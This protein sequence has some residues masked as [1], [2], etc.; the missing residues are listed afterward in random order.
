ME[1]RTLEVRAAVEGNRLVGHAAVF[2]QDALIRDFYESIDRRAFGRVLR[3]KQDVVLQVDH[4]GLPLART[5]AGTLH[6]GTDSTGLTIDADLAPIGLGNDVRVL[7]DRGDLRSMSFG[8]QVAEDVWTV[9]KDGSQ[10]RT[11]TEVGRLFDVS[12]VTF[13]AYAGTDVALRSEV[14]GT[15]PAPPPRATAR[16]QAARIRWAIRK[17]SQ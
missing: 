14:Y 1:R 15:L 8:F 9:R 10:H 13:P 2:D 16:G 12:V 5:T 11:I 7:V 3:E 17:A 6:L 4:Q